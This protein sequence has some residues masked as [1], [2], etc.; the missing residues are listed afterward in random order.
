VDDFVSR[1]LESQVD[2][3][4][5]FLG[6]STENVYFHACALTW[7]IV[8]AKTY[9]SPL[10]VGFADLYVAR[11]VYRKRNELHAIS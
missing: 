8:A 4:L 1:S 5:E 10:G 6:K 2:T 7:N 3:E 9:F 11:A